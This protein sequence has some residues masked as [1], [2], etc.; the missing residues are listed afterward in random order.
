MGAS[1]KPRLSGM[2]LQVLALYRGFLRAARTKSP[3]ER[4]RIEA[5]VSQEFRRNSS[6][7]D[8]K[9]YLYIEYL[10]RRGKKQLDQLKSPETVGL[11]SLNV[12]ASQVKR[13]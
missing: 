10:V 4:S 5:L 1:T 9:N 8:R 7:V 6:Q 13:S 11:A 12:E 3:E 2:Q